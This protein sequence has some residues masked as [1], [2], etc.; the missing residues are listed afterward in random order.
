M[1]KRKR[2]INI[3]QYLFYKYELLIAVIRPLD[4]LLSEYNKGKES[5]LKKG[6]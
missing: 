3:Y 6:G 1:F 5:D 2:I 4:K